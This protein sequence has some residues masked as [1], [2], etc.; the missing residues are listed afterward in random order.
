MRHYNST[1]PGEERTPHLLQDDHI[2]P[3]PGYPGPGTTTFVIYC[4]RCHR[5]LCNNLEI[6][7]ADY[8]THVRNVVA[9]YPCQ[10]CLAAAR[11]GKE[12]EIWPYPEKYKPAFEEN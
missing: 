3:Y 7:T 11:E 10:T 5:G 2:E 4:G 8:R 6:G 1:V 9:V 12:P